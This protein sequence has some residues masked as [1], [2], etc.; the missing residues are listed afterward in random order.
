[1]PGRIQAA[2]PR[3]AYRAEERLG[4]PLHAVVRLPSDGGRTRRSARDARDRGPADGNHAAGSLAKSEVRMVTWFSPIDLFDLTF[5]RECPIRCQPALLISNFWGHGG[6]HHAE[7]ATMRE[8]ARNLDI[9]VYGASGFV[10]ALVAQ[11]LAQ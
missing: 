10:G 11:H 2:S 1:M 3:G 7:S 6:N 5:C 4:P 8:P 9:V